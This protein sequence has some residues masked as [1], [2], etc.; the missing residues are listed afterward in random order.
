MQ[1]MRSLRSNPSKYIFMLVVHI[2]SKHT[3]VYFPAQQLFSGLCPFLFI[4]KSAL[5]RMLFHFD[6]HHLNKV[7]KQYVDHHSQGKLACS[8]QL[9]YLGYLYQAS[10]YKDIESEDRE[11]SPQ[12]IEVMFHNVSESART[13]ILINH[14]ILLRHLG[15]AQL[16][17]ICY[18]VSTQLVEHGQFNHI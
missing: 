16:V 7:M 10:S 4:F 15:L 13:S 18:A 3:H 9:Q 2:P 11:R 12:E 14:R 17:D 6:W 5:Q 1:P 8:S